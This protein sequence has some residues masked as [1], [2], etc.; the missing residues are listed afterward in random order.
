MVIKF[1]YNDKV[2]QQ[3]MIWMKQSATPDLERT[4]SKQVYMGGPPRGGGGGTSGGGGGGTS[5]GG[6]GT[7]GGGGGASGGGPGGT[8][9]VYAWASMLNTRRDGGGPGGGGPGGDL[10]GAT[11]GGCP[12]G[13]LGGIAVSI[14]TGFV[15][16][17]ATD[18]G[19]K[20][21]PS[22]V[23]ATWMS[24]PALIRACFFTPSCCWWWFL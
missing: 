8:R 13:G 4:C 12:G 5:G 1:D 18:V 15:D 16:E 19:V 24:P 20:L 7:S 22:V 14:N 17:A 23:S 6:G 21:L 10:G 3:G 9:G 2:L 11:A